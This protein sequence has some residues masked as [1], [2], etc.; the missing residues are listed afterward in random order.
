MLNEQVEFSYLRYLLSRYLNYSITLPQQLDFADAINQECQ[1]ILEKQRWTIAQRN[2]KNFMGGLPKFINDLHKH[3][4][5]NIREILVPTYDG[6]I[7]SKRLVKIRLE[8]RRKI[9]EN[10]PE[11]IPGR[12]FDRKILKS[13][14]PQKIKDPT[15]RKLR[16]KFIKLAINALMVK[17]GIAKR[18]NTSSKEVDRIYSARK[19]SPHERAVYR[20]LMVDGKFVKKKPGINLSNINL[21]NNNQINS[22]YEPFSTKKM[23]SHSKP[24]YAAY[25]L[26]MYGELSVF[27]HYSGADAKYGPVFHSAMNEGASVISA[28]EIKISPSGKLEELTVH[29]GHYRPGPLQIYNTLKFF[30]QQGIDIS[31]AKIKF[32]DHLEKYGIHSN[33]KYVY[34]P[35]SDLCCEYKA[36]DLYKEMDQILKSDDLVKK[37][38][39]RTANRDRHIKYFQTKVDEVINKLE[40]LDQQLSKTDSGAKIEYLE[41][42]VKGLEKQ[43]SNREKQINSKKKNMPRKKAIID[44]IFFFIK[45]PI[46]KI[47]TLED[48]KQDIALNNKLKQ[49]IQNVNNEIEQIINIQT[50]LHLSVRSIKEQVKQYKITEWLDMEEAQEKN[51][52]V[53]PSI[54]HFLK[55]N[56]LTLMKVANKYEKVEN[57]NLIQEAIK[58]IRDIRKEIRSKLKNIPK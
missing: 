30:K 40:V 45:Q 3:T 23:F 7:I 10:D 8:E 53:A 57:V 56:L 20:V 28:G 4:D 42:I 26:N 47:Y 12:Q 6:S 50:N 25:T 32:F 24:G 36:Q 35:N 49:T 43:I 58:D 2:N 13:I 19:F 5:N 14:Q 21:L 52:K 34:T 33:Y 11:Y 46:V 39:L 48:E 55:A 16:S 41:D 22:L 18:V 51:T 37:D 15:K 29:S 27:N 9:K 38:L 54:P 31:N 17:R 1:K 44:K